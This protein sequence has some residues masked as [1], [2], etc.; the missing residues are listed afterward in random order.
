MRRSATSCCLLLLSLPGDPEPFKNQLHNQD[1]A[2]S[3]GPCIQLSCVNRPVLQTVVIFAVQEGHEVLFVPQ[4]I[5]ATLRHKGLY[6][7]S[8]WPR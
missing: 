8:S 7:H 2:Q 4:Q 6:T 1:P 3:P 5:H